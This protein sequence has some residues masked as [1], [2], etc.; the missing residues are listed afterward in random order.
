MN[1]CIDL[2]LLP[3]STQIPVQI[4]CEI[5]RNR[6]R[7]VCRIAGPAYKPGFALDNFL[8][9]RSHVSHDHGQTEAISKEKHTALKDVVVREDENIGGFE[10]HFHL[11]IRDELDLQDNLTLI[12]LASNHPSHVIHILH[13]LFWYLAGN[14]Q[15]VA[16]VA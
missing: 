11:F 4:A 7:Q 14:D 13:T 8:A 15:A 9:E 3:F 1:V 10:I 5:C 6:L 16:R 12:E 2:Y